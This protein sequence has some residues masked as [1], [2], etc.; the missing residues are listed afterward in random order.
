M[1]GQLEKRLIK[2]IEK[3]GPLTGSELK[4]V[5]H[6][7][8]L[9]LWQ[10][11]MLSKKLLIKSIGT[12]YLRLD[13]RVNGFARL[14]PSI[15]REFLTYS[16]M[17]LAE[18]PDAV[19]EKACK[20]ASHIE[21]VSNNKLEL[22]RSI[23]SNIRKEFGNEWE[24]KLHI[25]FIIAGDIVYKMAHDVPRPE[26]STG[27]LVN[28][29]DIDLI[30]ILE[31]GVSDDFIK[32]LD[33]AIYKEKYRALNSPSL[34]EEIDYII[35][36]IS[37]V[38]EQL[39]FDTLKHMIACKILQEGL[40]LYGSNNLFLE[41]KTLLNKYGVT[42]MLDDLEK[43]AHLFRKNAEEYLLQTDTCNAKKESLNLFY[44]AEESEEFE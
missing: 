23:V 38:K 36:K 19:S 6:E 3:N 35:K 21:K 39:H 18:N 20:I 40:F 30:I 41:I 43:K 13:R 5:F 22:A 28:G 10:A 8:S 37:R 12:R 32:K 24:D 14:S 11:C 15:L 27:K 29:S 2:H 1:A 34:K 9:A 7:D 26:H 16:T 25:C 42:E 4:E 31:D 44:P 33:N 17:G